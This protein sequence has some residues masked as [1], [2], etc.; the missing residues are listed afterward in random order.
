MAL[1]REALAVEQTLYVLVDLLGTFAFAVSGA[2]AAKERRLDL[3]GVYVVAYM[4][5]CGGGIVRDLCLGALPPVGISDWR[6]LAC[7]ALASTMTIRASPLLER[8][9]HPVTFFDSLGLGLF[10][11]AGAHKALFHG[12]NTE[13]AIMLGTVTAVGGG[14][15]R[16]VLLARVPVILAK[17][18]YALAALVAAVIQVIAELNEWTI[19]VTSWFGAAVCLV[20][21]LLAL[22]Y[23]WGLPVISRP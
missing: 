6:Y 15:M 19:G 12:A 3:F 17:E 23:S 11:V 5:A 13:V 22:R 2:A 9:K 1:P 14:V 7:S 21:R 8:L 16:D 18:I 20:I 4:T 10:A